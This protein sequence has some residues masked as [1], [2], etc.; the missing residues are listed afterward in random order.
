VVTIVKL[1]AA[2]TFY[3]EFLNDA[4]GR[5]PKSRTPYAV[6]L[7]AVLSKG[8]GHLDAFSTSLR[9]CGHD[10]VDV[11]LNSGQLQHAWARD[12]GPGRLGIG[13]ASDA[14]LYRIFEQQV[15]TEKPDVLY[16]HDIAFLPSGF[17]QHLR[18]LVPRVVAQTARPLL[19]QD[20]S[21]YDLVVTSLP[22][23]AERF[24]QAGV[25]AEYLA[26]AFDLRAAEREQR[27]RDI[28][29]SFV[30]GLTNVHRE[31]RDVLEEV[32]RQI[33]ID[34]WGHGE[35]SLA[36]SSPLRRRFHG[37]AWGWEMYDVLGRTRVALNRHTAVAGVNANNMRLFEAT[38]MAACLVTDEKENLGRLFNVG[39]EIVTYSGAADAAEKIRFLL[40][41]PTE[42][43]QIAGAGQ[44]RTRSEHTY[45]HRTKELLT[46]LEGVP[47]HATPGRDRSAWKPPRRVLTPDVRHRL[48]TSP[49]GPPLR[50]LRD[51]LDQRQTSSGH[52]VIDAAEGKGSRL[53]SGWRDGNIPGRQRAFVDRQLTDLRSGSTPRVFQVAAE[54]IQATGLTNPAVLEVGCASGYYAEA[55]GYLLPQDLMY[56][57]IDYSAALI[58]QARQYYP[59]VP[60]VLGDAT[61]LPLADRSFDIVLSG[62]VLLHVADYERAIIESFRTAGRFVIFHRTPISAAPTT[63]MHKKAYG[64]GVVELVFNEDELLAQIRRAGGEVVRRWTVDWQQL[65]GSEI[66]A[67]VVTYLCRAHD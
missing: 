32:A 20:Y 40:D 34:V 48:G 53:A 54:A 58:L 49:I 38:G 2:D 23:F 3:P 33:P 37:P 28:D 27:T 17:V 52:V 57:G 8:F 59:H 46:I 15:R 60:F 66:P 31:G 6:M 30:G 4:L 29:V 50:R 65:A 24:R 41:H 12:H 5:A 67:E 19:A 26:L 62:C 25:R 55:L 7:D 16:I 64:I 21:S 44:R 45:E 43:E 14:N 51:L 56:V 61:H 13:P 18:D 11:V 10:V 1:L 36:P 35:T 47:A 22:H 42:R 39:T 9:A 63:W